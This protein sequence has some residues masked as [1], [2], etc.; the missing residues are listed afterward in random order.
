MCLHLF[1]FRSEF[2]PRS[3]TTESTRDLQAHV[4]GQRSGEQAEDNDGQALCSKEAN[5]MIHMKIDFRLQIGWW[6][7]TKLH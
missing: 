5:L 2:C 1:L 3:C 7:N 4:G 6:S